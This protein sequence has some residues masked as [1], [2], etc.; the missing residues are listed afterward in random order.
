MSKIKSL[1]IISV[2]DPHG[3]SFEWKVGSVIK[4]I[5]NMGSE[6]PD[7]IH[8]EFDVIGHDGNLIAVIENAPVIVEYFPKEE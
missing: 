6:F 8:S 7:S 5:E 2:L 4:A 1:R 3:F